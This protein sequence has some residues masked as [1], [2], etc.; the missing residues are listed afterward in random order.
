MIKINTNSTVYCPKIGKYNEYNSGIIKRMIYS[1]SH[2]INPKEG[3]LY[4]RF[5]PK[6]NGLFAAIFTGEN[7]KFYAWQDEMGE[8]QFKVEIIHIMELFERIAKLSVQTNNFSLEE[9]INKALSKYPID[10][11]FTRP[12]I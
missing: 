2:S 9:R 7:T 12:L 6:N 5:N 3:D 10:Q 8:E 1:H 11:P 4:I